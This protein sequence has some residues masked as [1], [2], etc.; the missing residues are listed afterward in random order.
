MSALVYIE[1][2]GRADHCEAYGVHRPNPM[3]FVWHHVLPQ[4]AGGKTE[5]GNLVQVCDNCHYST[6]AVMYAM[7]NGK[8]VPTRASRGSKALAKR[9]YEAAKAAGTISLIPNEGG[10]IAE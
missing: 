6:H 3:R 8:L 1:G 7:A 5:P 4:V 2:L 9:G 10:L